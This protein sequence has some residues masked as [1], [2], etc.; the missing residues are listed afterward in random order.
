MITWLYI[1][2]TVILGFNSCDS[3]LRTSRGGEISHID[4]IQVDTDL[5]DTLST[6]ICLWEK[7]GLREQPGRNKNI[8]Y[9]T[10]ILLGEKV[11]MLGESQ[12]VASENRTY[13]KVRL[14]D[15]QEGWVYKYLFG[16]DAK[17]GAISK[18]TSIYRRPDPMMLKTAQFETGEFVAVVDEMEEWVKVLGWQK[19]KVG[20]I[21]KEGNLTEDLEDIKVVVLY[22]RAV[23]ER[24]IERKV[25]MLKTILE[26][27][28]MDSRFLDMVKTDL[29]QTS[30]LLN[31]GNVPE[32][33]LR[34]TVQ[35]AELRSRPDTTDKNILAELDKGTVC[36]V[37]SIWPPDTLGNEM[38]HTKWFEIQHDGK[39]GWVFGALTSVVTNP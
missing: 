31:Q 32:N 16:I 34:I 29:N 24:E 1:S 30:Q 10:T 17:I 11:Y 2:L 4:S 8:K 35:S 20:W 6:A 22:Q 28:Q 25:D 33:Q 23:H 18:A 26:N 21:K 5:N 36:D 15:G 39:Q 19:K 14:S 7:V 9:I 12:K 3:P 27:T 38:D 13:I 37:I